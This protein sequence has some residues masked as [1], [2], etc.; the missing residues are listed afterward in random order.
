[1]VIGLPENKARLHDFEQTCERQICTRYARRT[2]CSREWPSRWGPMTVESAE[3]RAVD[4]PD[5]TPGRPISFAGN[6][7]EQ[8]SRPGGYYAARFA[9]C[10]TVPHSGNSAAR[11]GQRPAIV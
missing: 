4:I 2:P 3:S 8:P 10:A 9:L 7:P 5:R 6:R 1:M 11:L